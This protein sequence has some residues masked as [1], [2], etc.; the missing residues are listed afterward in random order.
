M[1]IIV[2]LD[3]IL[4]YLRNKEEYKQYVK[5]ILEYLS[6]VRIRLNLEKYKFYKKEVI[7]LGFIVSNNRVRIS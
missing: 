5:I 4:I 2:Y 7:F 3:N 1:F 6:K